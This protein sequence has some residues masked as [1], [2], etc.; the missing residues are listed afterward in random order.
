M[1]VNSEI[2]SL[3]LTSAPIAQ[4]ANLIV[5][6]WG[7]RMSPHAQPYVRAMLTLQDMSGEYGCD[8]ARSIVLYFLANASTWRG[9]IA[10]LV[11]AELKARCK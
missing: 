3:Q 11:K 2:L 1:P 7:T 9:P 6:D 8:S 4:L 10:K 5:R